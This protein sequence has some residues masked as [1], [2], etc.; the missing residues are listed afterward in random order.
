MCNDFDRI[1][2]V[3]DIPR[4]EQ[5]LLEYDYCP[6][7][8]FYKY[9]PEFISQLNFYNALTG[10]V[11]MRGGK[12]ALVGAMAAWEIHTFLCI[13]NIKEKLE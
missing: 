5:I 4:E 7:C 11:G 9:D 13:E 2:T 3:D 8:G 6:N 10:V 1:Y 12:S